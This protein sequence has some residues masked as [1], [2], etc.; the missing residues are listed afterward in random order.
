M[1]PHPVQK[2]DVLAAL[3]G[4][5]VDFYQAYTPLK[6]VGGEW[7][8][9]CPLHHGQ[10]A[11]FA[12]DADTGHWFCHSQCQKGGDLFT[13]VQRQAGVDFLTALAQVAAWAGVR[14]PSAILR[15]AAPPPAAHVK[16][17]DRNHA[18]GAHTVLMECDTVRLWLSEHRGLTTETLVRFQVGLLP[19]ETPNGPRRIAFPVYDA[20]G[21]LTNI[22][23][24]LFA[25]RDG[26]DRTF[27]T[28]PWERACAPISTRFR[29]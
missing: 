17:L 14:P 15:F 10:G 25:Y 4:R 1:P 20:E 13:F 7:R 18:E 5:Y 22:R 2:D 9:P 8:G 12:V 3:A 29:C 24:H 28:L 27:K 19:P 23:R 21:S 11:N 16:T 26:L 6:S